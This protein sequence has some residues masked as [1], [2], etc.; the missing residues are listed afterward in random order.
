MTRVA[1]DTSAAVPYLLAS[2]DAHGAV[3]AHLAGAGPVPVLTTHSLAETYSVLTRL[4]GDARLTADDARR[5][6]EESFPADPL[7]VDPTTA[8][9]LPS[10]LAAHGV[11]GGAVYDALVALAAAGAQ[12]P[13]VTR[14]RRAAAT[15]AALG[16]HVRV[17]SDRVP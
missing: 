13:L 11:T 17:V 3:R 14:D 2:H 5:L 7:A 4:P 8:R 1:L 9:R 6:I 12:T 16:V 10:E 15:Y